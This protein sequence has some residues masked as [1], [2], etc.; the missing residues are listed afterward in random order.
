MNYGEISFIIPHVMEEVPMIGLKKT[1]NTAI[2]TKFIIVMQIVQLKT[3][4]DHAKCQQKNKRLLIIRKVMME[5]AILL[6]FQ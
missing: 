1:I 2:T 6:N 4:E 5:C 3:L